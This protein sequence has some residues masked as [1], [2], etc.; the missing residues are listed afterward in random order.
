L[1]PV[2]QR[3]R[4]GDVLRGTRNLRNYLR[5]CSHLRCVK[6]MSV[7]YPPSEA[8][9]FLY[10]PSKLDE[11]IVAANT[12]ERFAVWSRNKNV[13]LVFVKGA[14]G[15]SHS[16]QMSP[17]IF[18]RWFIRTENRRPDIS[19]WPNYAYCLWA[20]LQMNTWRNP[21]TPISFY[22]GTGSRENRPF[23]AD[24]AISSVTVR[25][26]VTESVHQGV[27][28]NLTRTK[29]N[30]TPQPKYFTSMGAPGPD[31]KDIPILR[32]ELEIFYR[33]PRIVSKAKTAGLV[34]EPNEYF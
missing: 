3:V 22:G 16:T 14:G 26:A 6:A 5:V 20:T 7:N 17:E 13:C 4:V 27:F 24:T 25:E 10:T 21:H 2:I 8:K 31:L 28:R 29:N 11:F 23:A 18:A 33:D 32:K 9:S 12:H 34:F 1:K 19:S 15:S 30:K